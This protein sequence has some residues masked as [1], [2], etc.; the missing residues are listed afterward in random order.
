[1]P[2]PP[3][4]DDLENF[5]Q[6]LGASRL[7]PVKAPRGH[8]RSARGTCLSQGEHVGL[9][10]LEWGT[11]Q[12]LCFSPQRSAAPTQLLSAACSSPRPVFFNKPSPKY[13]CRRGYLGYSISPAS[14]REMFLHS[15]APDSHHPAH[16]NLTAETKQI[17]HPEFAR[18][19]AEKPF[20][21][22]RQQR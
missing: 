16:R 19:N 4:T 13:R 7:P 14:A 15:K 17:E 21:R 11:P 8:P 10:A 20:L 9:A 22:F 1:M 6:G 5:G 18:T 12:C 3:A 2:M